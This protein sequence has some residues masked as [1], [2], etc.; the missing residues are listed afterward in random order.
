VIDW[1]IIDRFIY[2][3]IELFLVK[4]L[5]LIFKINIL[6]N[7]NLN[8]ICKKKWLLHFFTLNYKRLNIKK[9]RKS[10]LLS[11]KIETIEF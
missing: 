10:D 5:N 8:I 3:K 6:S 7:E 2:S 11:D 4:Y 9:I 1:F